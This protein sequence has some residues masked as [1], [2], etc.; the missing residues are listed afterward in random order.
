MNLYFFAIWLTALFPAPAPL[1]V[2]ATPTV[3]VFLDPECPICQS[4]TRTLRELHSQF[5]EKNVTFRAVYTSP[6]ITKGD[7]ERFQKKYRLPILW[8]ID[9]DY[10]LAKRWK[11]T[12]TPEVVVTTAIG[13]VQYQGAI[14][15]WYYALG[16]NRPKP[17]ENYLLDALTEITSGQPV[18]RKNTQAV[19]CLIN[20]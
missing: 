1:A 15:N 7:I 6:G 19:G 2:E 12:T 16:K 11:A 10:A 17:T 20:Y 4:Y 8:T 3:W 18:S 5:G 13:A 9:Q 14:D